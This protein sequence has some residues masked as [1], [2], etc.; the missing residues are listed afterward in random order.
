M[1]SERPISLAMA[2]CR[3]QSATRNVY[4]G[5]CRHCGRELRLARAHT[6]PHTGQDSRG[7]YGDGF[8][9]GLRCGY[10]HAVMGELERDVNARRE[11]LYQRTQKLL[12]ES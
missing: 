9:C 3:P 6:R 2:G 1:S 4:P 11:Q 7:Q 10:A 12:G 5:V 8:F